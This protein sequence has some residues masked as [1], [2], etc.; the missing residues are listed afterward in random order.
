ML[1]E[2]S[3][4]NFV[5]IE[6]AELRPAPD[7]TVITGDTGAGKS[8]LVKA[9]KLIL[10][11]RAESRLV[12]QWGKRALVQAVFDEDEYIRDF[13]DERG[14]DCQGELIVRRVISADGKGQI[15]INSV[16]CILADLRTLAGHLVSIAGQHEFQRLLDKETQIRWLDEYARISIS[17]LSSMLFEARALQEEMS[18]LVAKRERL[19]ERREELLEEMKAIDEIAP[20]PGEE[21]AL[22]GELRLLKQV[23]KMRNLGQELYQRLYGERQSV[24]D[25]LVGCGK[26]LEKMAL[27]DPSLEDLASR[28][29]SLV[30][31][32]DDVSASIRDYL[33]DLPLDD[34]RLRQV[35]DRLF[36]LRS[37]KKR[38]GPSIEDVMRH[39]QTIEK[40]LSQM[41]DIDF[42]LEKMR[43]KLDKKER[44]VVDEA[45]KISKKRKEAAER[46]QS[47]VK[48]QLKE[49]NLPRV[50]FEVRIDTPTE[51]DLADIGSKGMDR[52]SF[53]FSA[54]PGQAL[55]PL[56]QVASGG[57]LSRVLLAI[58]VVMGGM[59][60]SETLIFDEIDSGLGGEVAEKVGMKLRAISHKTQVIAITHFPQIASLAHSH[61][62]V[63][64]RQYESHTA[65]RMF[66]LKGR[67][68]IQEI[69]RM[70][71][72]DSEKAKEYAKEL[73]GPVFRGT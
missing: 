9:F 23:E 24:V 33:F 29:E 60:E 14:I 47:A 32:A 17:R 73:L 48:E 8:L 65:S 54:N 39:R 25:G 70:L 55:Q 40:E 67:E 59:A 13:L 37:L 28:M 26:L 16:R 45:R 20:E 6:E 61:V 35:E 18:S 30:L 46:F 51:P 42:R 11:A 10:G 4:K 19:R 66:E 3:L 7:F 53:F 21:D 69:A 2:L 71:G 22:S 31:E 43:G 62:L 63:Q 5:L 41:E 50:R 36:K 57:E 72:G 58:K 12:G 27:I 52:V 1:R 56:S 68:R 49:L 34:S 64:K 15:F 38:F 44:E